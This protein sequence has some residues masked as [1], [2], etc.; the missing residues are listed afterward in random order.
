LTNNRSRDEGKDIYEKSIFIF[1]KDGN[2][3]IQSVLILYSKIFFTAGLSKKMQMQS[4][5]ATAIPN[6]NFV[7]KTTN[8]HKQRT[9][10]GVQRANPK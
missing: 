2:Q 1:S 3:Q 9:K 10:T 4:K 6:L 5:T 7:N 8:K